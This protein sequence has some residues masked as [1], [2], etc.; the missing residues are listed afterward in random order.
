[1][2]LDQV[3]FVPGVPLCMKLIFLAVL[4]NQDLHIFF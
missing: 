3:Y 4:N 1:M 2:G